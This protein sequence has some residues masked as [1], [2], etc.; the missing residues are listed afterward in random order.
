MFKGKLPKTLNDMMQ[1]AL[2]GGNKFS[3]DVENSREVNVATAIIKGEFATE[4]FKGAGLTF[5]ELNPN[6]I[7]FA[8]TVTKAYKY[9]N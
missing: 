2:N 4:V 9:V 5:Y 8:Q 3:V 6:G 1:S 7:E